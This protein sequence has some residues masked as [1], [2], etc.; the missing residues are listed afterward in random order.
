MATLSPADRMGVQEWTES[1][2]YRK[3]GKDLYDIACL[4]VL[5][6]PL[7]RALDLA[8]RWGIAEPLHGAL[9]HSPFPLVELARD[10]ARVRGQRNVDAWLKALGA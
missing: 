8:G 3:A 9:R 2:Y 5:A 1:Y 6:A 7:E 4:S 10:F